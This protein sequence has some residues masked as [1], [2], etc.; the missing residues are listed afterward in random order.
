MPVKAQ[1]FRTST[2][3]PMVMIND[4]DTWQLNRLQSISDPTGEAIILGGFLQIYP[5]MESTD[6]AKYYYQSNLIVDPAS[7]SNKT[8]FTLDTDVF[9]LNERLLTL[10]LV[11]KY[12]SQGGLDYQQELQDYAMA[13]AQEIARDKG[14]RMI[15][16]GRGRMP[17]GVATAYPGSITV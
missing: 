16:L 12:R 11:W 6:S 10:C 2:T 17:D 15:V 9:V 5:A 7:G 14:S 13:M 1:I 8:A 3:R 4:L